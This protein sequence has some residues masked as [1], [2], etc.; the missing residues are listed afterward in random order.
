LISRVAICHISPTYDIVSRLGNELPTS[1]AANYTLNE[2][3]LRQPGYFDAIPDFVQKQQHRSS[4]DNPT[5]ARDVGML[6]LPAL[7]EVSA[8]RTIVCT[9]LRA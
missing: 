4:I 2:A 5:A 9:C 3:C 6:A 8:P 7:R 1:V